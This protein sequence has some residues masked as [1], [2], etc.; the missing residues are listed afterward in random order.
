MV[1]L[2]PAIMLMVDL[3]VS[4]GQWRSVEADLQTAARDGARSAALAQAPGNHQARLQEI[5]DAALADDVSTCP[6]PTAG[7]GSLNDVRAGGVV[8]VEVTCTATIGLAGGLIFDPVELTGS[9]VEPLNPYRS[10]D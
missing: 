8:H 9:A 4:A 2:V 5:A 3:I 10:Y 7:Y 1:I 6:D